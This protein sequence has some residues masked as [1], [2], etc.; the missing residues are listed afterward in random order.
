VNRADHT[1]RAHDNHLSP[2]QLSIFADGETPAEE[3]EE[4]AAHLASCPACATRLDSIHSVGVTLATLGR[5]TPSAGVFEKTMAAA[6]R[7]EDA[8]SG[9]ARERMGARRHDSFR[10]RDVRFSDADT[11]A[12]TPLSRRRRRLRLPFTGALPTIAA[13]LLIALTGGLLVRAALDNAKPV[14]SATPTVTI[15]PG[16][17]LSATQRAINNLDGQRQLGFTAAKPTYLPPGAILADAKLT[18]LQGGATALDVS[19]TVNSGSVLFMTLREQPAGSQSD[20]YINPQTQTAGLAWQVASSQVWRPMAYVAQPGWI[21]V[22]QQR[23]DSTLLLQVQPAPGALPADVADVIA[24]LRFTSLSMDVAYAAPRI[25]IQ[26]PPGSS[27]LRSFALVREASGTTWR[28][29]VTLSPDALH[30]SRSA[31]ITS[32]SGDVS[33]TEKTYAGAG[34]L[35]D[36]KRSVYQL[37]PGPTAYSAPPSSVTEIARA[38]ESFLGTGQLW[39]LGLTNLTLP[40]GTMRRVYDL[41]HVDTLL[42]E[43]VYADA[44]TGAVV[45]IVIEAGSPILPGG[46]GSDAPYI[47]KTDCAP[48]TVTYT[49]LIFEPASA[50]PANEFDTK[51]PPNWQSGAITAPFTCAG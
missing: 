21:G 1:S 7:I 34:V 29:D 41:Y 4:I 6:R 47:S 45:A 15:P 19:W 2:L 20:G 31:T 46:S 27:Y 17:T 44:T 13:L 16:Q 49:E 11:S 36:N 23:D 26:A 48:Y 3:R 5:T 33:V 22:M 18:S 30:L 25:T 24:Q 40:D 50:L 37:V 51:P 9:V 39:N 35:L 38:P 14:I 43:H 10:L 12:I 42:P 32:L 8:H 28:W